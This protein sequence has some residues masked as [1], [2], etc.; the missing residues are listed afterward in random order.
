MYIN[1]HTFNN[2]CKITGSIVKRF[3]NYLY[4]YK[5]GYKNKSYPVLD[6]FKYPNA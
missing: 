2:I 4:R 6:Q 3:L 1:Y 5:V